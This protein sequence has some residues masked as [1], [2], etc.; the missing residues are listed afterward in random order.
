MS[1]VPL[2]ILSIYSFLALGT[3]EPNRRRTG[4][5]VMSDQRFGPIRQFLQDSHAARTYL[6]VLST[7]DLAVLVP[8]VFPDVV[9]VVFLGNCRTRRTLQA[10]LIEPGIVVKPLQSPGEGDD[11]LES[12]HTRGADQV[13]VSAAHRTVLSSVV[14]L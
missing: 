13:V 8:V 1:V 2:E 4:G 12:L 10:L 5:V 9:G 6:V 7:A 3:L 14:L 11:F